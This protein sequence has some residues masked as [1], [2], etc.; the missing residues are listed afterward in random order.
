[1]HELSIAEAVLGVVE[2]HAK[3]R[4]VERVEL[5]VGHLRQVVPAAL[6]LAFELV[7]EGT[8]AEGA[9]LAIEPVPA[10]GDCRNCGAHTPLPEFPLMC[11]ECG[12]FNVDV[13]EGEELFVDSLELEEA[14]LTTSGG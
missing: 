4:K 9:E 2:R 13:T 1:M 3:G 11:V 14:V 8:V 7:A 10:A 12:A 5:N 6:E